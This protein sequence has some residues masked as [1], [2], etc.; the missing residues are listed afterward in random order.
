MPPW[1]EHQAELPDGPPKQ[2][3]GPP[4]PR[5]AQ[6]GST[7]L[8]DAPQQANMA[9]AVNLAV[10]NALQRLAPAEGSASAAVASVQSSGVSVG[11]YLERLKAIEGSGLPDGMKSAAKRKEAIA[12]LGAEEVARLE[13]SGEAF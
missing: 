4:P 8:G 5:S 3:H 12:Y 13:A 10:L 2:G 6:R 1:E 7:G 11:E 9:A